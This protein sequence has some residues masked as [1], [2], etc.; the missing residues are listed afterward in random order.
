MKYL[1]IITS[2]VISLNAIIYSCSRKDNLPEVKYDQGEL[3]LSILSTEQKYKNRDK[4]TVEITLRNVGGNS[5]L[6]NQ[7]L[8][9][10]P[11]FLPNEE[12]SIVF[13]IIN[14]NNELLVYECSL[15]HYIVSERD[16]IFLDPGKG[17]ISNENMLC[18][19]FS[20]FGEYQITAIYNNYI[21][22]PDG[23]EAWKGSLKS[24]TIR[25]EIIP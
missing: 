15:G 21:D 25:I 8:I 9:T 3:E 1:I 11:D 14:P 19:D 20:D 23:N 22:K 2:V 16:F 24:N 7:R 4:I 18:F 17:I 10:T 5:V 12:K 13:E 6:I